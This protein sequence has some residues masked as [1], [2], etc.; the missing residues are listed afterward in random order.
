[1]GGTLGDEKKEFSV[2]EKTKE[3]VDTF[4]MILVSSLAPLLLASLYLLLDNETSVLHES[5]H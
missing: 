5:S 3:A 2:E 4:A 1:M